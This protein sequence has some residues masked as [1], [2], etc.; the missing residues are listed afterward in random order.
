MKT[1]GEKNVNQLRDEKSIKV[2]PACILIWSNTVL[3]IFD[4]LRQVR[5]NLESFSPRFS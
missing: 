4:K 5:K 3:V 2:Q 1:Q